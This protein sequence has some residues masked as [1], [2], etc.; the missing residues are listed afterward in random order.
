M[1]FN[2]LGAAAVL[3]S[4]IACV[5]ACHLTKPLPPARKLLLFGVFALL[6]IPAILFSMYYLHVL[7]ERAWFYELRS[8]PGTEFLA[9]FVG[10]AAGCLA[11]FLPNILLGFPLFGVLAFTAI[12][13]LKP[14]FNPLSPG[15]FR[16]GWK[17]GVCLQSTMAS[18]GPASV[19]TILAKLGMNVSEREM[20]REAMT[21]ASGTEAWYLARAVR[22]RGFRAQFTFEDTFSGDVSLPA[23]VGVRRRNGT[24]PRRARYRWRSRDGGGSS[25]REI[26]DAACR[27]S[28]AL[29]L[30]GIS[31]L[32]HTSVI[33]H[34]ARAAAL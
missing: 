28:T 32:D 12:P 22:D 26:R 5:I 20:A 34:S 31:S 13:Y 24:F 25:D 30:L 8:W 6:S 14:L 11:S 16:D 29:R 19:C 17:D 4:L 23:I 7:P 2:P 1:T 3:G 21:C 15:D 33:D 10:C 18:C 27:V 9:V